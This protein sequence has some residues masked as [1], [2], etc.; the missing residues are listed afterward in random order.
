MAENE[1]RCARRLDLALPVHVKYTNGGFHEVV[2]QTRNLSTQGVLLEMDSDLKTGADIE[3]TLT[4][5][6]EITMTDSIRVRCVGRVVRV[7]APD[8]QAK[9]T[10]AATIDQYDFVADS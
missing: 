2:T 10:V 5:P 9:I 7:G 8:E 4:L 1:Q 6:P 3:F